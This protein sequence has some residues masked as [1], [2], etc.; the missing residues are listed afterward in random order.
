MTPL[1][2]VID[3]DE[4]VRLATAAFIDSLGYR[5]QAFA[6]AEAYL[7]GADMGASDCLIV[8]VQ[9]PGMSGPELQQVLLQRSD[10]VPILF[11]TAFP[12]TDLRAHVLTAGA[13]CMLGKPCEAK[14]LVAG[15]E[16]AL[17]RRSTGTRNTEGVS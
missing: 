5:S 12:E 14:L 15:I 13:V 10:P 16:A 3:D 2:S 7:G 4:E 1:I 11:V 6:S 8:D 17:A 9:M